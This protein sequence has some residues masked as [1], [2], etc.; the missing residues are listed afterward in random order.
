[1]TNT[2]PAAT[3]D[4][5]RSSRSRWALAIIVIASLTVV[6]IVAFVATRGSESAA[7]FPWFAVTDAPEPSEHVVI[8]WQRNAAQ[9]QITYAASPPTAW[10]GSLA[11][12]GLTDTSFEQRQELV[13]RFAHPLQSDVL[14]HF[15]VEVVALDQA[16]YLLDPDRDGTV[17]LAIFRSLVGAPPDLPATD[18][19][20]FA[21][22]D[23]AETL[24]V[25]PGIGDQLLPTYEAYGMI[26]IACT[27]PLALGLSADGLPQAPEYDLVPVE[28]SCEPPQARQADGAPDREGSFDDVSGFRSNSGS[29]LR[30]MS[31]PFDVQRPCANHLQ[32][33]QHEITEGT[34]LKDARDRAREFE[35]LTLAE[36]QATVALARELKKAFQ[37]ADVL[38]K[39][40]TAPSDAARTLVLTN[41][42]RGKIE[43][44]LAKELINI[45]GPDQPALKSFSAIMFSMVKSL[46]R[47]T[48]P[49]GQII[50]AQLWAADRALEVAKILGERAD[51][52][53]DANEESQEQWEEAYHDCLEAQEENKKK[54]RGKGEPHLTTFDGFSYDFQGVGEYVLSTGEG[55]E[56]QA[57][58]APIRD[59]DVSVAVAAAFVLPGGVESVFVDATGQ[60]GE[61]WSVYLGDAE[62]F[63]P[64][65]ASRLGTYAVSA[66]PTTLSFETDGPVGRSMRPIE[67]LPTTGSCCTRAGPCSPSSAVSS[68]SS[69]LAR[70]LAQA[71]SS[72]WPSKP[73]SNTRRS[74]TT[75]PPRS[76]R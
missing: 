40:E 59:G 38:R 53:V 28:F 7:P 64:N 42:L 11:F 24:V 30:Q 33:W 41:Y 14:G 72:L 21:A 70:G 16:A 5:Q 43:G 1:M 76:G 4:R 18:P 10:S 6:A 68:N 66:S 57:R 12:D 56:V 61:G 27:S 13:G 36:Q 58:Y 49:V 17:D 73:R 34:R 65:G 3:A 55:L 23:H 74:A 48:S 44:Q 25:R 20:A 19:L 37:N 67:P 47:G 15:G 39:Y 46:A 52:A 2:S 75:R 8:E 29:A 62:Y 50:D 45:Y 9:T 35:R 51:D 32:V 63:V 71:S 69:L 54:A 22:Y 60:P 26:G 31:P